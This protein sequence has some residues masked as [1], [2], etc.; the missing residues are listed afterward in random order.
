MGFIDFKWG[1]VVADWGMA[2]VITVLEGQFGFGPGICSFRHW[3]QQ[4]GV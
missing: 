4:T 3:I 1:L 2:E